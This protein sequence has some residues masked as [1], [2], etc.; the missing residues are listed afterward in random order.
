MTQPFGRQVYVKVASGHC[1]LSNE[2]EP[3]ES[4]PRALCL[5]RASSTCAS[6]TRSRA[7]AP[8]TQSP[9]AKADGPAAPRGLVL[10]PHS[11]AAAFQRGARARAGA[12]LEPA[13]EA[14]AGRGAGA[15]GTELRR[16]LGRDLCGLGSRR[17]ERLVARGRVQRLGTRRS[18]FS[19]VYS[20]SAAFSCI[21]T[22][23]MPEYMRGFAG[24]AFRPGLEKAHAE[25]TSRRFLHRKPTRKTRTRAC[26]A[27]RTHS[28]A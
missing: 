5:A 12:S 13:R 18:L 10:R 11:G 25:W 19:K 21:C 17:K 2:R 16:D 14:R 22:V 24:L 7:S 3:L 4:P 6:S 9:L 27:W 28:M 1:F 26:T 15:P 20:D 23:P 8:P